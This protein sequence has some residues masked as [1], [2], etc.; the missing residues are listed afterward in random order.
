LIIRKTRRHTTHDD[1]FGKKEK[2]RHGALHRQVQ[3]EPRMSRPL[4]T[5]LFIAQVFVAQLFV[6]LYA[7]A[8]H[9]Q[10]NYPARPVRIVVLVQP[11]GAG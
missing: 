1:I 8:A 5:L 3:E 7:A 10:Q 9:A 6:A 2:R 11:G 4:L